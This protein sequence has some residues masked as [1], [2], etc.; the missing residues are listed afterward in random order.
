MLII[1]YLSQSMLSLTSKKLY[2]THVNPSGQ[3]FNFMVVVSIY[4]NRGIGMFKLQTAGL[5]LEY[6]TEVSTIRNWIIKC[7]GLVFRAR[8]GF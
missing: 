8:D 5:S 2:T 4:Y 3:I 6:K 1:T 7:F